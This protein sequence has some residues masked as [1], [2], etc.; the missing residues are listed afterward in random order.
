MTG[1]TW[2]GHLRMFRDSDVLEF[3][4]QMLEIPITDG[5]GKE[6]VVTFKAMD[7]NN[8]EEFYTDSNALEMQY[9][10]LNWRPDGYK[11]KS[12]QTI[13]SNYYPINSAI[14]IRDS[15]TNS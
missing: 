7:F 15:R 11:I 3:E 12:N 14:A 2:T 13:T 4:V 8:T 5:K 1:E 6:V 10:K 9:R